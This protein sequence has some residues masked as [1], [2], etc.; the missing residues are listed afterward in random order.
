MT[1]VL[2]SCATALEAEPVLDRMQ[3]VETRQLPG[4]IA[5]H[6]GQLSGVPCDLVVT[7]VGKA[8]A[9]SG[10]AAALALQ[11]GAYDLCI[12]F[13]LAGVYTGEFIPVGST[14]V[15]SD[16]V[17]LDGGAI[18]VSGLTPLAEIGLARLPS[19]ATHE[20][21]FDRAEADP[22][23]RDRF[24][25]SAGVMPVRV[26][27]SDAVSAD[28]D[29]ADARRLASG[30]AVEAMEGHAVALTALRF[31]VPF[32]EIRAVSN[33]AGVRDKSVWQIRGPLRRLA[34]VLADTLKAHSP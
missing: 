24:A 14:V 32:A 29:I 15:A 3:A 8:A 28:L 22:K 31:G 27:T 10:T 1:R 34:G 2:L 12:S 13:G 30:A 33:A 18:S 16:E 9:A 11:P 23:W 17:D 19:A 4:S 21:V 26:A 20:A 7:G 5:A 6:T 25:A